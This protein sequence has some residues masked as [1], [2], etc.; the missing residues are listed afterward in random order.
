MK[1]LY[2]I[3]GEGMGHATRSRVILEH[4]LTAGHEV[5][6][7]VSGRAHRFLT[8]RFAGRARIMFEE[9]H[10]LSMTF[11][12][13]RLDK[14]ASLWANVEQLPRGLLKNIRVYR[15]V[16][17]ARFRPDL[18]ISDF[19]SWA[20]FYG[21]HHDLPVVSI[22]N[23]QILNRCQHQPEITHGRR[24]ERSI[25][26]RLAKLAVKVKLPRAYHYLITSFFFP[27]VRKRRTTLVPPILRPEILN[28]RR[29]PGNHV[30]VYR[31]A[32]IT[33]DPL[34]ML[35]ALPYPFRLYGGSPSDHGRQGNVT[36]RPFSEQGFVD[37]L[38]TARAV[39]GS[40]GFSLMGEAVHLKVPMMAVPIKGQHEQMLNARYLEQ[41]G[42]GQSADTLEACAIAAFLERTDE[43]AGV[44]DAY[45][46]PDNQMTLRCV[47]EL[48]RDISLDEP[49]VERL[50]S[51]AMG[52]YDGPPIDEA[53]LDAVGNADV[54]VE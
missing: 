10:G 48:L 43:F 50:E 5:R 11:D 37:D 27:P 17:E 1:I 42:Y 6:V 9:I 49:P 24:W 13:D 7:V 53:A 25:D 22:D 18:V 44:L 40:A 39:I 30:L 31:S 52:K 3:V 38:R 36:L 54:A 35:R 29:E 46:S 2:G 33:G 23:M 19:E 21:R 26:F 45:P 20:Y 8:D 47:D 51:H 12:G 32:S 15:E 16:A 14:S 34:P 4:L 41:L 28:A